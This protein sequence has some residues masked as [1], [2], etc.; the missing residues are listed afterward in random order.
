MPV[1]TLTTEWKPDDIYYGIIKG[2]LS[3]MS[4]GAI[5]IDNAGSIPAFNISH[6]SFIIRNTYNNYPKGT[7]H[8][9]CV[10]SEAHKDQDYLIVK[11]KD[12]FFIGTDNGIFNLIL[13]SEPDEVVKIDHQGTSDELDI[14]AKAAA[15]LLS[16][17]NPTDL[18]KSV[19]TISERVPLRATIDKD[20]IIGSIIFIDSYGNAISNVTREVFYRV[21]ENKD[22]RILIQSNK[23]YTDHISHKYS[24]VPVGE[25]LAR[26]NQFDLLEIS[27]NG[28][29][30]SEL[31]SITV[32]SVVRIDLANKA[33]SPNRL[34]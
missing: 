8:I 2:K 24:D 22:Y 6:A 21:F 23:N 9:I 32:G 19:K 26:F 17:K 20:V 34:F 7:V 4:P 33:A 30:V 13:N 10:H 29:N 28:A 27:I 3:S 12:H 15:D 25:M 1:I 16:G 11:A 18:G 14:F 31:L 5:I